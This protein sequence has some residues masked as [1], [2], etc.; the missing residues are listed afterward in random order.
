[1][2]NPDTNIKI[3]KLYKYSSMALIP[4]GI[5]F[6]ILTNNYEHNNLNNLI[7]Y[8]VGA[9]T[10]T[11]ICFHSYVSSSMVLN[12]YLHKLTTRV[13]PTTT[14]KVLNM[15]LHLLSLLGYLK[16]SK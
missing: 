6:Y 5:A 12:D 15:N 3:L 7:K 11:N 13:G 14:I 4:Q 10:A 9:T 2:L 8:F 1:M 16:Y